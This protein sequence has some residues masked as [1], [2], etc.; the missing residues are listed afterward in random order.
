MSAIGPSIVTKL[1][2]FKYGFL[3]AKPCL[4]SSNLIPE[5]TLRQIFHGKVLNKIVPDSWIE[6]LLC[7]YF[8]AQR[9]GLFFGGGGAVG[10]GVFLF[11]Y[12]YSF[13]FVKDLFLCCNTFNYKNEV[14]ATY[15]ID[16]LPFWIYGDLQLHRRKKASHKT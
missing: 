5:F 14:V 13:S 1:N 15:I 4:L 7:R 9:S 8:P 6:F 12:I 16:C 10:G 11:L 3:L 2:A